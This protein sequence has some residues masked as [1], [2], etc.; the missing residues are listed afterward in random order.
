MPAR[1]R[2]STFDRVLGGLGRV[3]EEVE[4]G[5]HGKG[6]AEAVADAQRV[7]VGWLVGRT[8]RPRR[9]NWPRLLAA[10]AAGI[11]LGE[12]AE[13]FLSRGR[14]GRALPPGRSRVVDEGGYEGDFAT[15]GPGPHSARAARAAEAEAAE[16][17]AE[18]EVAEAAEA[19]L[20]EEELLDEEVQADVAPARDQAADVRAFLER[21][22]ADLAVAATYA[23][24]AYPRLPGPPMLRAAVFGAADVMVSASG[25]VAGTL[26]NLSPRLKLPLARLLPEEER[27]IERAVALA[28][29][30]GLIYRDEEE[31]ED[32][33]ED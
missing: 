6:G 26:A 28:L 30:L 23:S 2:E 8:L 11:V 9:I 20:L 15:T 1:A 5:R 21:A 19:E 14:N 7:A 12:V 17:A 10:T 29:A 25:G 24:I 27:R 33:D 16:A 22:G 3:L 32:D 4:S 31:E 13:A 18:A